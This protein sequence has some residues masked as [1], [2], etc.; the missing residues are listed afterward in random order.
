MSE[1]HLTL[2]G[3]PAPGPAKGG[4]DGPVI[5]CKR[6]WVVPAKVAMPTSGAC[7]GTVY[8]SEVGESETHRKSEREQRYSTGLM[9][10]NFD[11]YS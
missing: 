11:H 3:A 10:L 5:R 8:R 6:P 4:E 2:T 9:T 7:D 1:L